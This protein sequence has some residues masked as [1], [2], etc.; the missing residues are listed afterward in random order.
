M[1][2]CV[3]PGRAFG[4]LLAASG[5]A[6]LPERGSSQA[7]SPPA[8]VA[9]GRRPVT[10]DDLL[11]MGVVTTPAISPD[12][13]WVAW[14]VTHA[15]RQKNINNAMIWLA[16]TSGGAPVQLTRG[17][18]ADRAPQWARDGTW[19]AFLSDRGENSRTQVYGISVGGGEAWQ[20]TE[21]AAGV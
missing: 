17:P 19:L 21:S 15:D 11:G 4:L 20:I 2:A 18:R 3:R 8:R 9:D 16:A 6:M 5:V 13:R 12:G 1:S 14:V 7:G 10:I